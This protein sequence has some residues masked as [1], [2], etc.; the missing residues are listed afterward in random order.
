MFQKKKSKKLSSSYIVK[1]LVLFLVGK[2]AFGDCV[3]NYFFLRFI[4]SFLMH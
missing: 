4:L 3:T 1:E 2:K